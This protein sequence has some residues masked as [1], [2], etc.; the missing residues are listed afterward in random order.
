MEILGHGVYS[1]P[2]AARL[3][4]LK[5]R[6]VREWFRGRKQVLSRKPILHGDYQPISGD[7]AISFL[8][9]IDLFVVG[10]LRN[11]GVP[12]QSLRKVHAQLKKELKTPHPFC[13]MEVLSDGKRVFMLGLDEQNKAE[14]TEVLTH[15]RVFADILLPFLKR[16]NY[17]TATRLARRWC[18]ADMVVI[19]PAI[20]LGKPIIG[21]VGI[22]TS[23]LAGAYHANK[24]DAEVVADWYNIHS[25]H[26]IA[27]VDFERSLVA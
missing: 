9:L 19:D 7:N 11:H 10:Q 8:D 26:V 4:R 22:A 1:L 12:L 23:I 20:C 17:D 13:R 16:I 18:I 6:R 27:A 15:Q 24:N 2:E 21:E 5:G 14:M 25:K 3:T